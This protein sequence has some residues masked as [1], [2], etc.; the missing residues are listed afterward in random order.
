MA[1]PAISVIIASDRTGPEL[2]ACLRSLQSQADAPPF[3]VLV[4]S[5][6]EPPTVP[7]LLVGWVRCSERNPAL[8]RNRAADFAA[9]DALAFLDDDARAA[10]DWVS[11]AAE[12]A[13]IDRI[14]G[15]RDLLPPGS[16][17]PERISDLLLATPVI[18]SGVA[19]HER[20][21]RRGLI[22]RASD[23]SLCNLVVERSLFDALGGFDESLGYIG[24]DT[25]FIGRAMAAG[26][27]P[28]LQPDLVVFHDR[29]RFPWAFLRQRWRYRWKTGRLLVEKPS[30]LPKGLIYGFLAAG[31][32]AAASTVFLG[33]RFVALA[34]GLYA[35]GVWAFSF[36]IWR[37]DPVLFPLAPFGFAVHHGNYWAATVAGLFSALVRAP[38]HHN[39]SSAGPAAKAIS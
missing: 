15:G 26:E 30:S 2:H 29:R 1:K 38:G 21:P 28:S 23:L 13:K 32:A 16:T 11:K 22:R 27:E 37:R 35:I 18:G 10:P 36:P 4:A 24:E 25:D 19:A 5:A 12:T 14:F 31:L 6:A 8:R 3:E 9:G 34:G 17:I 33:P 7:G 20:S 39:R